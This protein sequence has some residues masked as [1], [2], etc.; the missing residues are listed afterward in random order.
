LEFAMRTSPRAV[1]A[2]T[3]LVGSLLAPTVALAPSAQAMTSVEAS[4]ANA[5]FAMI[6]S[7]RK[8]HG[9]PALT[10]SGNLNSSGRTHN[11]WMQKYNQMS[12]QLPG[13]PWLGK[14]ETNAGYYWSACGENIAWNSTVSLSGVKMLQA[15]MYNE[16]APYDAHRQNILSRDFA[17]V[18]VDVLIDGTHHKVWLTTDFGH[19]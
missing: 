15:L 13:E 11:R 6:N 8:A 12:H 18:G 19:H 5:V 9:V 17:N 2:L 4:W 10:R 7:E 1:L 16:K 14:R 3:A